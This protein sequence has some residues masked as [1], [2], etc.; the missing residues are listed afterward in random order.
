MENLNGGF[1]RGRTKVEKQ[2]YIKLKVVFTSIISN[3]INITNEI[4]SL[5]YCL[6]L[7]V[8]EKFKET[9]NNAGIDFVND[10]IKEKLLLVNSKELLK[11][12]LILSN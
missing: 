5:W 7:R 11:T 4:V 1:K 6:I 2:V 8:T 9:F 12:L 10:N 3:I